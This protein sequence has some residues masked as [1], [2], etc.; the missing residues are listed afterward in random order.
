MGD[1]DV[2]PPFHLAF[3]VHDLGAARRFYG[4]LLGLPEGRCAARWVDFDLFGHQLSAHLVDTLAEVGTNQVDGDDVPVRHFGAV[5]AWPD[6]EAL[7]QRLRAAG[8]AFLIEPHVRFR[9]E[10]GEQG[11]FFLRDPSGNALE[12]KSFRDPARLFAR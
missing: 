1:R 6:W 11:T 2:R 7:A 9:G 10:T 3:P 12:F 5:L 8:V 4:E